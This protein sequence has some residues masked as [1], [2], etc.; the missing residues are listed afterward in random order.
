MIV[1]VAVC[2][3]K[4][5]RTCESSKIKDPKKVEG[6]RKGGAEGIGL[7]TCGRAATPFFAD[8]KAAAR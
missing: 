6:R 1:L 8:L 3:P 5:G 2:Q 4:I 7:H